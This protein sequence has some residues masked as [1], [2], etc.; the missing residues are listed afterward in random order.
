MLASTGH[1]PSMW[2]AAAC[3]LNNPEGK[4]GI[5]FKAFVQIKPHLA[6]RE[7]W[8]SSLL[9]VGAIGLIQEKTNHLLRANK[10]KE[11]FHSPKQH[12]SWVGT[13]QDEIC[14]L[15]WPQKIKEMGRDAVGASVTHCLFV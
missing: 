4:P 11:T 12:S 3:Q 15:C 8:A 5:C 7:L 13:A 2:V 9:A 1:H 14:P 6:S 10:I